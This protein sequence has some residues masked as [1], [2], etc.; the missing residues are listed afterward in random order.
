M[1][2]RWGVYKAVRLNGDPVI[3]KRHLWSK[4]VE[5]LARIGGIWEF[6]NTLFPSLS[7]SFPLQNVTHSLSTLTYSIQ[8]AIHSPDTGLS[9]PCSEH[10]DLFITRLNR[11]CRIRGSGACRRREF[12]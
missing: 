12:M 7:T 10:K 6:Y 3:N 9:A 5:V 11:R 8:A 4:E 2:T 1:Y